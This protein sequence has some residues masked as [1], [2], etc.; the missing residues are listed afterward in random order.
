MIYGTNIGSTLTGVK[1]ADSNVQGKLFRIKE[2][3]AVIEMGATAISASIDP[4][5]H[6]MILY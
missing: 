4:V 2:M 3:N 6:S 5:D 1:Y